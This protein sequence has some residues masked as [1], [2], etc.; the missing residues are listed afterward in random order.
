MDRR[1]SINFVRWPLRGEDKTAVLISKCIQTFMYTNPLAVYMAKLY[2]RIKKDG[3]WTWK[4]ANVITEKPDDDLVH[5]CT[6]MEEEE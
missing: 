1:H 4:P 2:W 6:R 3:K 5:V